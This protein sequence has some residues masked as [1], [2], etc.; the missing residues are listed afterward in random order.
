LVV[1]GGEK[2]KMRFWGPDE[3][4]GVL[5]ASIVGI[6]IFL[7]IIPDPDTDMIVVFPGNPPYGLLWFALNPFYWSKRLYGVV[8]FFEWA[9]SVRLSY[10][11]VKKGLLDERLIKLNIVSVVVLCALHA[12]Q[13]ITVIMFAPLASVIPDFVIVLLAQKIPFPGTAQWNCAF[14]GTGTQATFWTNP[15]LSSSTQWNLLGGHVYALTYL[16]LALWV[17]LPFVMWHKKFTGGPA[18]KLRSRGG[19]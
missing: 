18:R 7:L 14:H 11:F 9:M 5:W 8:L 13:D 6:A 16:I 3:E 2:E 1:C 10:W 17:V 4:R 19:Q 15:C 12:Y